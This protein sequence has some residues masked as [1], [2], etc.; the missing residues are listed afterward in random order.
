MGAEGER[1]AFEGAEDEAD[2]ARTSD[3]GEGCNGAFG[4]SVKVAEAVAILPG[5]LLAKR[6]G[7]QHVTALFG[8]AAHE[9]RSLCA[10]RAPCWA[11]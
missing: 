6:A 3:S 10:G 2:M 11:L 5:G 4:C 9:G 1:A 7:E 8:Q